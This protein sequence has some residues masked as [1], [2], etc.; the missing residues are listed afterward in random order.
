MS[1][2]LLYLF[3]G[4]VEDL[5]GTPVAS[6]FTWQTLWVPVLTVLLLFMVAGVLPGRMFFG[7]PRHPGVPPVHRRQERMEARAAGRAV[8]RRGFCAGVADG[9]PS[10]NTPMLMNRDMGFRIPGLAEGQ[11][12]QDVE[13]G[14]SIVDYLRRQPYVEGVAVSSTRVLGEYWTQ[15]L[16]GNDGKRI[17]TPQLYALPEGISRGNGLD[18]VERHHL[19]EA[20]RRTGQ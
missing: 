7:H 8:H 18:I 6:L 16:I 13:R 19:A 4:Q 5:L 12:W 14:A 10:C 17:A 20:G 15:G 2:L 9:L 3:R 11:S 1:V